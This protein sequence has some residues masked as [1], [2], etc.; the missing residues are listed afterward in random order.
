MRDTAA[1]KLQQIAPSLLEKKAKSTSASGQKAIAIRKI[2][3]DGKWHT[4]KDIAAKLNISRKYASDILRACKE[5]WGL[6]SSRRHG[7][8]MVKKDSVIII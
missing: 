4:S 2:L 7:W 5:P 8:M 3:K 6:A 1:L